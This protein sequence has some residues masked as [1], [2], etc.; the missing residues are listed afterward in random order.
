MTHMS[1]SMQG[2]PGK[3][4]H[5]AQRSAVLPA[6][7][8]PLRRLQALKGRPRYAA[9]RR[10]LLAPRHVVSTVTWTR[11]TK[12]LLLGVTSSVVSEAAQ[13]QQG[14]SCSRPGAQERIQLFTP[15]LEGFAHAI[16]ASEQAQ[17]LF[18]Q[19]RWCCC[20]SRDTVL[21]A[22]CK[23]RLMVAARRRACCWSLRSISS[24]RMLRSS[25]RQWPTPTPACPC[26]ARHTHLGQAPT[27][28]SGTAA[29][30]RAGPVA[31]QGVLP[32]P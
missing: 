12:P 20:S 6:C 30:Q 10:C 4:K 16:Q 5:P 14:G 22:G 17:Q 15:E 18:S 32:G 3:G 2:G 26:G 7:C 19:V 9:V 13:G 21:H 1:A 24:R 11:F 8:G 29:L 28:T 31:A 23:C 25:W 27:G